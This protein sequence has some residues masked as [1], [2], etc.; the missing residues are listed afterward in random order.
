MVLVDI[1]VVILLI[2]SFLGGMKDGAVKTGSSLVALII[3]IPLTTFS[4]KVL[5]SLLSFLPGEN[6]GNFLGFFITMGIISLILH[7]V[8]FL[9]RKLIGAI[10]KKG[11]FFRLLGGAL[12][13]VGAIIGMI[14]FVL[15][16]QTYPIFDWLA[17]WVS[18]SDV[19]AGLV[20]AFSFVRLLLPE[21]FKSSIV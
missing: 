10:W 4:Y 21:A 12:S 17:R 6:W 8:F 20:N 7:I 5:A 18:G 19:L 9:P 16:V 1:I 11:V 3:S 15:L 13:L 14:V 2:L